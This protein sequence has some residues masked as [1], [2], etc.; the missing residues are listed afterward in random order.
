MDINRS[1][2]NNSMIGKNL[3]R[4]E[5]SYIPYK[6]ILKDQMAVSCI[7]RVLLG[8]SD[9]YV[10]CHVSTCPNPGMVRKIPG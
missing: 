2:S 1:L 5:D 7:E 9:K 4:V 3:H 8:A 6:V 10:I